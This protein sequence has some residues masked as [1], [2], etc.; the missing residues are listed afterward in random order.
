MG[1][2]QE[3][4]R[5]SYTSFQASD[6]SKKSVKEN[7]SQFKT[8]LFD[9]IK[10]HIPQNTLSKKKSIHAWFNSCIKRLI[11]QKQQSYN[12]ARHSNSEQDWRK[13]RN[14]RKVI[15][16]EM[17]KGHQN[18]IN[19]LLDIGDDVIRENT[20]ASITKRFWQY[21][22]A[23][24]KDSSGIPILKSDGKEVTDSKQ[25]ADILNKQYNSVF[26]DEN[27]VLPTLD[28]SDIP[29]MLNVTIDIDGVTK[30]L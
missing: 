13:F 9:T 5:N 7:W 22:K 23:K 19:N 21:I 24:C 8:I 3:Q 2:L 15:H 30:L 12:A 26:T 17:R 25:K 16:N 27:P 6:P 1:G 4:L 28:Y 11:H 29:D 20:N 10:K 14:L 18:Y